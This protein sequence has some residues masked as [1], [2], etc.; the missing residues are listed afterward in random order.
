MKLIEILQGRDALTR[1]TDTHF[2]S[3]KLIRELALLKKRADEEFAFYT[4][5]EK[6]I[7]NAYADRDEKGQIIFLDGGR[8]KL[9]DAEAKA[10]FESEV[11]KL[12]DTEID[13]MPVVTILE[14][15]FATASDFPTATEM[16]L[17]S[18]LVDFKEA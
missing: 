6:R 12:N 10:A 9:K 1:L 4:E 13:D 8:V 5:Q 18:E 3:Y 2:K 11:G 14:S 16:L 15:D 7:V 17:L